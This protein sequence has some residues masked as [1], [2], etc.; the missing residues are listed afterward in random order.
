MA[1]GGA[2]VYDE[3][4][5]HVMQVLGTVLNGSYPGESAVSYTFDAIP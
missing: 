1:S 3:I 5:A 4:A 2:G